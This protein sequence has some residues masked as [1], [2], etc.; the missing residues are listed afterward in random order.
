[1]KTIGKMNQTKTIPLERRSMYLISLQV[2]S[3]G[4][5]GRR[6]KLL[7]NEADGIMTEPVGIKMIIRKCCKQLYA[8]KFDGFDKMDPFLEIH[9]LPMFI[10]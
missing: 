8:N 7:H 9:K 4:K 2:N 3:T 10:Q 5:R 1:M 6:H